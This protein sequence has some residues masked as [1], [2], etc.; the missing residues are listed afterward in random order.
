MAYFN[1]DNKS[2]DRGFNRHNRPMMMH[3]ATGSNCGKEC[4]VPFRP[5]GVKPV[6]CDDCFDKNRGSDSRRDTRMGSRR[7]NFGDKRMYDAIC[8]KCGNKCSVPFQPTSGKP[9]F[10][11]KCFEG[12]SGSRN[13]DQYKE[14]FALLNSKLDNILQLLKPATP[15]D[16]V[17]PINE[18]EIP[19][20]EKPTPKAKV[21]KPK[22]VD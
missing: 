10:C 22:K 12:K 11:S 18:I 8:D 1:R 15:L 21:K 13:T 6:F 2:N 4:E 16:I 17:Q 5:T 19:A 3:K 20:V 9:I 14:Q 7:S